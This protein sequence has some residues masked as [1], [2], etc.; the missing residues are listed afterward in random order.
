MLRFNID[1]T[2][3]H[4]DKFLVQNVSRAL[5]D[6]VTVKYA[7]T[8]LRDTSGYDIY[9]IYED[10]FLPIHVFYNKLLEGFQTEKLFKIRSNAGDKAETSVDA[11]KALDAVFGTHFCIRLDHP[12]PN[13]HGV[14]YPG[15]LQRLCFRTDACAGFTGSERFRRVKAGL[16]ADKHSDGV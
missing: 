6:K 13:D 1:P 5:V 2:C 8:T 11:E 12:I 10:L 14:F 3:A 15:P 4:A 7:G 9:K 16:Q